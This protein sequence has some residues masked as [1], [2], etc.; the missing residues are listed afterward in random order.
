MICHVLRGH[1]LVA[2]SVRDPRRNL[3]KIGSCTN[4]QP[5]GRMAAADKELSE[6]RKRSFFGSKL[7]SCHVNRP[8]C[9]MRWSFL[10]SKSSSALVKQN[11]KLKHHESLLSQQKIN[12][13]SLFKFRELSMCYTSSRHERYPYPRICSMLPVV[14]L[15]CSKIKKQ[16]SQEQKEVASPHPLP[17][18]G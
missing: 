4:H 17:M 13:E 5:A 1:A 10:W 12:S 11:L 8:E 3:S 16:K 18:L 9:S 6:C 14:A 15:A 7:P 2:A